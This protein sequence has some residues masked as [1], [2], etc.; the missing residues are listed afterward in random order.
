MNLTIVSPEKVIYKGK[1]TGVTVPGTKGRFEVLNDH[2]PIISSLQKGKL[3]FKKDSAGPAEEMEIAG[4]F[5]N[6]ANNEV[7]V[8]VEP[9]E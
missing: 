1:A 3:A 6:V 7:A 2:A 5:I 8:C 4:G 9:T